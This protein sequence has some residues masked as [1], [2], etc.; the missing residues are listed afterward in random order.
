M[1]N[2]QISNHDSHLERV[3]QKLPCSASA[4]HDLTPEMAEE[5]KKSWWSW[6]TFKDLQTSWLLSFLGDKK[7]RLGAFFCMVVGA[8]FFLAGAAAAL[9]SGGLAL[10]AIT[11]IGGGA[12]LMGGGAACYK[13]LGFFAPQNDI[14][15]NNIDNQ[16]HAS[17]K[18]TP[19][20]K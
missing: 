9:S 4:T 15:N 16:Q 3:S 13:A 2:H 5:N 8:G 11:L 7:L 20:P 19:S 10:G 6:P 17:N 18:I 14:D 1:S 12:I